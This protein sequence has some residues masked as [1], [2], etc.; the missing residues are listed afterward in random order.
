MDWLGALSHIVLI[1]GP[2]MQLSFEILSEKKVSSHAPAY[3]AC[4]EK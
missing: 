4:T 3:T 2:K 1:P